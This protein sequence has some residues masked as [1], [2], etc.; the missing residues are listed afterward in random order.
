M[1]C[2]ELCFNSSGYNSS[3]HNSTCALLNLYNPEPT[4]DCSLRIL[5]FRG[6][7]SDGVPAAGI[8]NAGA[9]RM[10]IE[11]SD[12]SFSESQL[13]SDHLGNL[14]HLQELEISYCKIRQLPPRSFVGLTRLRRLGIHTHT[15]DWTALSLEPDYESFIGLG[16]LENLDLTHNHLRQMPAG[17]LC[18]LVNLKS[19]NISHNSFEDLTELGLAPS[20]IKN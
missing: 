10:N 7:S 16:L 4:V 14:D 20:E 3:Y 19:V 6:N 2:L 1:L 15:S 5:D 17:L 9:I 11:C 8:K 18:P 13:R 12:V